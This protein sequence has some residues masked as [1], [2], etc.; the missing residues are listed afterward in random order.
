MFTRHWDLC[1]PLIGSRPM[2]LGDGVNWSER[3]VPRNNP[4]TVEINLF[5]F[6]AD[7]YGE[8]VKVEWYQ[9]LEVK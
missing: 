8:Q 1:G 3:N 9:Y 6:S 7:I 5:D 2:V 4:V